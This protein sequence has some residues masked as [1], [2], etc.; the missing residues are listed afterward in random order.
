M[1]RPTWS[2]DVVQDV[3]PSTLL[4]RKSTQSTTHSSS[5]QTTRKAARATHRAGEKGGDLDFVHVSTNPREI[6]EEKVKALDN[7]Y[8]EYD[9]DKICGQNEQRI[10]VYEYLES[11]YV[12][13]TMIVATVCSIV[14]LVFEVD[15][16]VRGERLS[17]SYLAFGWAL[18]LAYTVDVS[19]RIYALRSYFFKGCMNIM[20]LC[21]VVIDFALELS[22]TRRPRWLA[23]VKC[24]R[25]LRLARV[26]RTIRHFRDLYLMVI[27][28]LASLRTLVFGS[29]LL[30]IMITMFG[31]LAVTL[32]RPVVH[33][34]DDQGLLGDCAACR[35]HFDSVMTANLFLFTTVICGDGWMDFLTVLKIDSTTCSIMLLAFGVIQLLVLNTIAAVMVDRQTQAREQ[36]DE[37]MCIMQTEELV[38]SLRELEETFMCM[39]TDGSGSTTLKE[40]IKYYDDTPIFRAILNRMD[41]HKPDLPAL[42]EILD[43]DG[44]EEVLVTEFVCGLHA[45]KNKNTHTLAVFTN[46]FTRRIQDSMNDLRDMKE[47]LLRTARQL[48]RLKDSLGPKDATKGTG[49]LVRFTGD[50]DLSKTAAESVALVP[51]SGGSVCSA[52]PR[53][54]PQSNEESGDDVDA[55]SQDSIE[56]TE[57]RENDV[58]VVEEK[59]G[60]DVVAIRS[61]MPSGVYNRH[62]VPGDEVKQEAY[63]KVPAGIIQMSSTTIRG[64]DCFMPTSVSLPEPGKERNGEHW[65][66]EEELAEEAV[67]AATA[68]QEQ[69]DC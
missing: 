6:F 13:M 58:S 43:T 22:G 63:V 46:H 50:T 30:V 48:D 51:D 59:R 45:I 29:M 20:E 2:A 55:I 65:P 54:A 14:V 8:A 12:Q 4:G 35:D 18:L 1:G 27:G 24:I 3:G 68:V 26:L 64:K 37:Y 31:I 33:D 21:L 5:R 11:I 52:S 56:L 66:I 61:R 62:I 28:L 25:F 38:E 17:L 41:I 49:R 9:L 39:D 7:S 15:A 47:H 42:F 16:D 57:A 53:S 40:L 67:V 44:S 23:A 60:S 69:H 10:T 32:I 34:L 36:D 19:L